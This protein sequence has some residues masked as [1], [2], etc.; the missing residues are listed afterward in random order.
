MATLECSA[1]NGEPT[2]GE[3]PQYLGPGPEA[4]TCDG[5]EKVG[6]GDVVRKV[7]TRDVV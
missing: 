5:E 2:V 3:Q 4:A 1:W 7:C 6:S